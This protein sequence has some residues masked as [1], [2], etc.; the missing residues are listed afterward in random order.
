MCFSTFHLIAT[1]AILAKARPKMLYILLVTV[2]SAEHA[3]TQQCQLCTLL[4]SCI[5]TAEQTQQC[6]CALQC[7]VSG[8]AH[9]GAPCNGLLYPY[10]LNMQLSRRSS[11]CVLCNILFLGIRALVPLARDCYT[12]IGS[13]AEQTQQLCFVMICFV[14]GHARAGAPCKGLLYPYWLNC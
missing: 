8:R 4:F 7:F 5:S 13:T 6:L 11:V 14:S 2:L 3:Q 9:T 10:W 12:L 1:S